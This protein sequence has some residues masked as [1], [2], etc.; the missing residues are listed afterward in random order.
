MGGRRTLQIEYMQSL[1]SK[2]SLDR[3]FTREE[4]DI[5]V[6]YTQNIANIESD[7][8]NSKTKCITVLDKSELI[9]IKS[10]CL[11]SLNKYINDANI[12]ITE[13]WLNFTMPSK[14]HQSHN[15]PNSLITG[16]LYVNASANFHTI[17]FPEVKETI[18]VKRGDLLLFP[19][20][21]LYYEPKNV[22]NDLKMSLT[23]NTSKPTTI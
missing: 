17:V 1:I 8:G 19:S 3:K 14:E 22:G 18:S 13:S 20:H 6:G 2:L 7:L 4:K 12:Y 11:S 5:F 15:H 16:I 23:F 10:F 21:L 9:D